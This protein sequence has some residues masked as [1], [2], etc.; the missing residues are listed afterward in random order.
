MSESRN[1]SIVRTKPNYIYSIISVALVLFLLGIF[2]LIIIF[3]QRLI[4]TF[5]EQVNIL[6]ELQPEASEEQVAELEDGLRSSVYAKPKSVQY[7]SKEEG[8]EQ[9]RRDFGEDFLKL[10]L[11]NPLYAL[12]TF[13]IKSDYMSQDSLDAI[14]RGLRD[15][16]I[17]NDVYYQESLVDQIIDNMQ[18]IA[19]ITFGAALFLIFAA[20][21]LIHNTIRLALYSNRFLI[22]NMELVGASWEFIS[23]PYIIR[24]FRHGL[25]SGVIAVAALYLL[26]IW[27]RND[28]PE[29]AVLGHVSGTI[30]LFCILILLGIL[31][32]TLSSFYIVNKY[33]R[34]R[35]NDLY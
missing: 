5:K 17:V 25:I 30:L 26:M 27:V 20:V 22:K 4:V 34:M 9:M 29:M 28:L 15:W 31:I 2:G 7:I 18:R 10:D 19:Y 21:V 24:A 3:G 13:N 32:N 23:R 33:L 16:D 6:V 12:I 1:K 14:R 11:P 8:A 35:V